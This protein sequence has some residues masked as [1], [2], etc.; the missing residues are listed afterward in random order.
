V[1]LIGEMGAEPTR[2]RAARRLEA[3][4]A[5][6]ASRRLQ[7]LKRLIDAISD[8]RLK[9]LARGVAYQLV[10]QFGILDRR[11]ADEHVRALSRGE[12]RV[13]KSLG[14][15]FGAFSLYLPA[16]LEPE[17]QAIGAVFAELAAP[18]FH[19]AAAGL[20]VLPHPHPPAEA[21]SL[22]GLIA[23]AGFAAPALALERF[24]GL[25]RAGSE[26]H[27]VVPLAPKLVDELGWT[28][29]QAEQILRSL[30]FV[31]VRKAD[32]EGVTLW[33]R[34]PMAIPAPAR[35]SAALGALAGLP[36]AKSVATPEHRTPRRRR[37]RR[38]APAAAAPGS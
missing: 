29:A 34:R 4:V 25:L 2:E 8:G 6:E 30:G 22:R 38:R 33:R 27:P 12:R 5:A 7:P 17:A 23:V 31:R 10:E 15:R 21:M 35:Q 19:P 20:S 28:L 37:G 1:R 14:V 24:D 32:A 13:L 18:R 11:R 26:R 3:F 36:R 9:G 16:L